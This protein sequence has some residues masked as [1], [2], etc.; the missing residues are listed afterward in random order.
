MG[1]EVSLSKLMQ[2]KQ[3]D[4]LLRVASTGYGWN[5]TRSVWRTFGGHLNIQGDNRVDRIFFLLCESGRRIML[6]RLLFACLTVPIAV[7]GDVISVRIALKN[8]TLIL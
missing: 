3:R 2:M 1:A 8:L 6:K 7:T 5:E 4:L